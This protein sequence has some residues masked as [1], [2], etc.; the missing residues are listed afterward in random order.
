M[1]KLSVIGAGRLGRSLARLAH[2]SGACRMVD[3][4]GRS[5]ASLRA[6]R[7]FI[8]AGNVVSDWRGLAAADFYLL[9]VP[10]AAIADCARALAEADALPAGSVAFHASGAGEAA[11]L[12]PLARRG[13]LTASLH[14]AFSFADPQRAVETFAGTLCALEGN[15][16]AC[17]RLAGLARLLGGRPF[18]LAPGG[19]A[20]YHAGLSV[21]S[22]YL[23]ALTAMAEA[24]ERRAGVPDDLLGDLLGGLMRQTLDNALALGPYRALTGPVLRGDAGTVA[25]HLAVLPDAG[26]EA[27]YRAMG[28]Q[29]LALAGERLAEPAR[30][31]MRALLEGASWTGE[32]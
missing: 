26:A 30:G 10:D 24:L 4:A 7:D 13:V 8:G 3:V 6:A 1:V 17:E 5:E 11:L 27:A 23:V 32:A 18:R 20:A 31:E 12:A 19:K 25:G 2:L 22:N 16:A 21:A 29:T 9:A 14:P 28:L 15:E